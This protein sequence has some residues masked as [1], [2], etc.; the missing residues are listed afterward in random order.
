M[1]EKIWVKCPECGSENYQEGDWEYD[2][3][4]ATRE[5]ECLDCGCMWSWDFE[6]EGNRILVEGGRDD[7]D[8]FGDDFTSG[9]PLDLIEEEVD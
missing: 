6:F 5:V 7:G 2:C 9:S 1:P 8:D 3:D 4:F